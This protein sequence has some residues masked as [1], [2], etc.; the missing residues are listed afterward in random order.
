MIHYYEAVIELENRGFVPRR[1]DNVAGDINYKDRWNPEEIAMV[2]MGTWFL[3]DAVKQT[4]NWGIAAY[5][6]PASQ[7][8][9]NTFG[10]VTQLSIPRS[11]ENPQEAFDFIAFV[12]GAEGAAVLAS[13]GQLPAY[14][15]DEALG[16]MASINGFPQDAQSKAALQP[17]AVFLEQPLNANTDEIDA[18][19]REG[20]AE[21]MDRKL[22]VEDAIAV[23]E[24]RVAAISGS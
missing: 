5:P 7:Y 4:F 10:N 8:A 14:I 20:H 15:T 12:S 9:G 18:I 24:E 2:N 3:S 19:L 21:I 22:S 13:T 23:M 16:I 1:T 11:A 17:K 6:V